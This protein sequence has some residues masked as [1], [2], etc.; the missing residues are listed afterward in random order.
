MGDT[1]YVLSSKIGLVGNM[2]VLPST[3]KQ[4]GIT[5]FLGSDSFLRKNK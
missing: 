5:T 3:P 4:S 1:L 2:L